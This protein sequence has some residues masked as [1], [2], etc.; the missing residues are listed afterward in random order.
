MKQISTTDY[1]V[2]KGLAL[3][4]L[5]RHATN[6]VMLAL[7]AGSAAA[8]ANINDTPAPLQPVYFSDC[9]HLLFDSRGR[10]ELTR[11]ERIRMMDTDIK[12]NLSNYER[13]IEAA[14]DS[15]RERLS[16]ASSPPAGSAAGAETTGIEQT[17]AESVSSED[18]SAT[19]DQTVS[20]TAP[21]QQHTRGQ[22]QQGSSSVCDAIRAGLESATTDKEKEHFQSLAKEYGC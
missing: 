7:L 3:Q 16:E 12:S 19:E 8:N 1:V 9:S 15:N 13:C 5:R 20:P 10:E 18:E 4:S 6:V 17:V 2:T 14:L 11:A 21:S 22:R